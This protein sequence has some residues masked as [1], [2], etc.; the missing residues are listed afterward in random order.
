[1]RTVVVTLI[2]AAA[3]LNAQTLPP[4]PR[5]PDLYVS[6]FFSSSVL[7][8]YGPR[9]VATGARPAPQQTGAVYA[10]GIVRRPWGIAFGPDGNAYVANVSG[11]SPAI[12]RLDG[13]FSATPGA[14]HPLVASGAFYDL[15]FG[16]DRNLYAAGRGPVRRY[17]LVTGEP[18]DEFTRGYALSETRGIAFG[19]DGLLYVSNYDSCP[20]TPAGCGVARGEIVR[21]DAFS[22]D[23][24]DVWMKSGDGPLMWPWNLAFSA[25]GDL[26]IV[27]WTASDG[28]NIL[29]AP[30][31]PRRGHG[32]SRRNGPPAA[33]VFIAR[34]AWM[35]LYVAVGPDRNIYVSDS[36][37]SG[38][39]LRFDGR[40]GAFIDA[41]VQQVEGGPR[42]I[43]FAPGAR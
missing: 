32:V 30:A 43:T 39:V 24:V 35:P 26:L 37:G 42:G 2:L 28:N 8:Y 38:G 29:L 40:T 7:R 21:F 15:A 6:G 16:P 19:P 10:S 34:E 41:F 27:N 23:F 31:R 1:M 4:L 22:G 20:A 14:A 13:P 9:S 36:A 18:I 12:V 3:T 33:Q 5:S 25:A 11:S 17:D